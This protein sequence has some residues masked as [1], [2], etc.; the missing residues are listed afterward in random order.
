MKILIIAGGKAPSLRLIEKE[1]INTD[2]IICA[3][4]GA[5][6]LFKYDIVPNYIIGDLDSIE[7]KALNYFKKN[8]TRFES[9]MREKN[10]TDSEAALKKAITL[11]AEEIVFLGCT[12]SRV[13]HFLGN[14][15][16]LSKCLEYSVDASIKDDNNAIKIYN[17]SFKLSGNPGEEFS[18]QAYCNKVENLS[19]EGAK[20]ELENYNLTLGDSRTISNVFSDFL[21]NISFDSGVLLVIRSHD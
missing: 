12:G 15:G 6:C 7:D 18:L 5:N 16:L 17:K 1:K 4:S 20:Y 3:D 10:F 9:Y 8:R 13:D 14:I 21:V 19:I 11:G 2:I